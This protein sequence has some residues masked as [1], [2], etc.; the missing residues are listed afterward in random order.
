VGFIPWIAKLVYPVAVVKFD[1]VNEVPIRDS[2]GRCIEC[3]PGEIGE[4]ISKIISH[5]PVKSFDGYTDKKA[6]ENKILYGAFREG[7]QYFRSGDL[8][9]TDNKGYLYFVDRIGDTFRWK[10]ENVSTNEVTQY[11][12]S[13][14]DFKEI[15]VYGVHVPGY[16]GRTGMASVVLNDGVQY[17][18]GTSLFNHVRLHLA[19]YQQPLFIRVQQQMTITGTFK[20]RKVEMVAEG[21]NSA[22]ITDALYFRDDN[23]RCY[24]PLDPQLYQL[25]ISNSL[26]L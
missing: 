1:F 5:D 26:R 3:I 24:V 23:K 16:D 22:V 15:N 7:D 6:T 19:P 17:L 18:D 9:V 8:L 2:Q 14:S 25:I 11:L 4:L 21:F 10:G 13:Y 20:H 12:S